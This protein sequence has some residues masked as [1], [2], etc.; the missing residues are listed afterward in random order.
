MN[1]EN[2]TIDVLVVDDEQGYRDLFT[3]M[4]E[5]MGIRVTCVTNGLEAL[6]KV[7]EKI[8][9]LIIM[10]VHM[11]QL[12]GIETLKRIKAMLPEQKVVIFS[13]SSDPE[14]NK[15]KE[16]SKIGVECLFKPV[17]DQEIR[18]ILKKELN[19]DANA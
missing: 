4:L 12:N 6:E 16:A 7:K 3:Y 8:F 9:D 14:F 19:I 18:R 10:D 5:P 2:R 1:M 15:E 17:D 11:P 13:S